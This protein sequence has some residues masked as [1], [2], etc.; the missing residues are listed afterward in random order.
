[1]FDYSNHPVKISILEP[2]VARSG[3]LCLSRVAVE[4]L[5]AEDYSVFCGICEDGY[6]LDA[7]ELERLFSIPGFV[8]PGQV[9]S[10]AKQKLRQFR[11]LRVQKI[12]DE[13]TM[14]NSTYFD[15]EIKELKKQARQAANLPEKLATQKKIKGI[16]KTAM[17]RGGKIILR[18]KRLKGKK[19]G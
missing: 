6:V 14:R 18:P 3:Y 11:D 12:V 19:I 4:S 15:E 1:M 8:R 16:Q 2:L 5:E 7:V 10:D 17:K 9:P 13:V